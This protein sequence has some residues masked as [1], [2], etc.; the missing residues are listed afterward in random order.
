MA[1]TVEEK[2]FRALIERVRIMPLPA[3]WTVAANI[4]FPGV[5]FTPTASKP[6]LSIE[7]HFNRSI[8][9]D[10]SMEMDPI[11]QGFMRANVM[12]PKGQGM[13]QAIDFAGKVR[14]FF[15]RGTRL[16]FEGTRTD[17]N[18][19]PELG[20]HITG[21]THIAQPVTIRWQCMP[22]VPA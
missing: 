6:F 16:T 12:W 5:A 2:I 1:E 18:E 21:D 19:D 20:P 14:A 8:E 13:F 9:T 4:A 17:I 22:A 11:R 15:R 3:G 7:V 10:I